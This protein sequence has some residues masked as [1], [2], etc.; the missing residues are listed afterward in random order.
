[1]DNF[2]SSFAL[3]WRKNLGLGRINSGAAVTLVMICEQ[4]IE[5]EDGKLEEL[6]CEGHVASGLV[7][8]GDAC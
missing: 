3:R 4:Q 2:F 5:L 1:M 6:R 7:V 8:V